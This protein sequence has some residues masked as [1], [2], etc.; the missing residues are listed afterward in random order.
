MVDKIQAEVSRGSDRGSAGF[1]VNCRAKTKSIDLAAE[2]QECS[3]QQETGRNRL[4]KDQKSELG[5]TKGN[6]GSE[7]VREKFA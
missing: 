2:S 3:S 5:M 1:Q 6:R 4:P 7:L